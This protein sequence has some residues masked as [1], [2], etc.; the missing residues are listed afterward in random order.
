MATYRNPVAALMAE[1]PSRAAFASEV[2]TEK[3]TVDKWATHGRIPA[4]WFKAV[5]DAAKN[6]GLAHVTGEWLAEIHA[7]PPEDGKSFR[8]RQ[9]ACDGIGSSEAQ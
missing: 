5:L 2:G 3:P 6:R 9:A 4:V 7:R 8:I 1:W